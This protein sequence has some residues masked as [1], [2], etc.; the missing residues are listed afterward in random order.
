MMQ[1]TLSS[2]SSRATAGLAALAVVGLTGCAAMSSVSSDVASFGEWPANRAPGSYAF[3]R[4]PSQESMAA[5]TE[6]LEAAAA[7]ALAKAGFQP[8]AAGQQPDVLVQVGARIQRTPDRRWD[9]SL[10]WSGGIG[11]GYGWGGRGIWRRGP[12]LSPGFSVG[13]RSDFPR[14]DRE[15]GVLIRDR[16]SGKALYESRATN[17]GLTAAGVDVQTAMF[18][19]ALTDFPRLAMNPRRVVV[20]LTQAQ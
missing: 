5:E 9:E 17:E 19:A 1:R 7:P 13:Y 10:W 6:A 14:Y 4:L 20:P 18:Q 8:A 15:V 2:L 16:A 11:Y 3:E 12:W